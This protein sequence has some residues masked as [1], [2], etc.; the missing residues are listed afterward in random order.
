MYKKTWVLFGLGLLSFATSQ[1]AQ[2][3]ATSQE[4][5]RLGQDLTPLGAEKAGNA[6]GSI[7]AWDGGIK[8]AA[9]AGFPD[10][11]SGGHHPDPFAD[12][13]ISF[14]INAGNMAEY[15]D[16]LT[17]GHKAL[18]ST[19][20]SFSMNVYPSH[21]SAAFPERI[22]AATKQVAA[23]AALASGDNGVINAVIGIPFPMPK[24][25]V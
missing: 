8:S 1:W 17:E 11:K 10:F 4:V 14:T 12:D 18:M 24:S 7:P 20:D 21:R 6:D 19:Y 25:G 16:S 13:A 9:D 22:Y 23:S 15:A 3:E 5:A 2:S